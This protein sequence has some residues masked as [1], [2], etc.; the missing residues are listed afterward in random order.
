MPC[1]AGAEPPSYRRYR[2][3][4]EVIGH[5][6][7][8]YYRFHLTV[9]D[10]EELLAERG[11]TVTYET[12][13]AWCAKF[14]QPCGRAAPPASTPERQATPRRGAAE[15]QEQAPLALAGGRQSR[16]RP[17]HSGPAASR[18]VCSRS[19]PAARARGNRIRA[20][21]PDHHKPAS[22]PPAVRR[23]LPK[24]EHRRHKGLNNRA[25]NSHQPTRQRE[26]VMRRFKS[27]DQAQRFLGPVRRGGRPLP[28]G[29]VP[30]ACGGAARA[31]RR[32]APH[33]AGGRR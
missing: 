8:L 3:P 30:R 15:D 7:W 10:V 20:T 17:G 5:A 28:H 27:P 22:Y 18:S 19:I 31:L 14:G 2:Y 21:R 4:A 13:R 25:E 23:V 6:V 29:P 24:T 9:R 1:P 32:S 33:V 26:R 11:I 12:I 16:R